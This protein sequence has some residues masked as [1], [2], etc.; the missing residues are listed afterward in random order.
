MNKYIN[1]HT[2]MQSIHQQHGKLPPKLSWDFV[3]L[4]AMVQLSNPRSPTELRIILP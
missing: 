3:V 1:K 4:E 2:S